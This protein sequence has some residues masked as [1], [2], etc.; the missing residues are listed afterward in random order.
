VGAAGG[1]GAPE[2]VACA[3]F[4]GADF[5]TTG[6]INQCTPEA[7]TSDAVKD[8]L[9]NVGVQDTAYAPAGDMFEMGAKVQVM[10]K[11]VFFPARAN[12]LYD[13]WRQH[14]SLDALEG[15]VRREIQ[16]KF[17]R[18]SFEDVWA[19]TRDHYGRVLPAELAR[20]EGNPKA[21]MG[22]VFRWYFVHSMR[23]ALRGESTQRV[24]YQVH[25]GPAM[26]AFNQWVQG[27]SL[28]DWRRRH[29][30]TVAE[31]LMQ[32]ACDYLHLRQRQLV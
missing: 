2:Q 26:G 14:A 12:K 20:V 8:M 3:F 4:L 7:G 16:D 31:H 25:C 23:L 11:G 10:K 22:L 18:R 29:G 27:T 15:A 17:F 5:I 9:Q 6:S 32:G 13:L 19:E 24:D 21:K 1:L 28:E 30:D